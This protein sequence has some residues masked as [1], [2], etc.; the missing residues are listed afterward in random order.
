MIHNIRN[1]VVLYG[2]D[3]FVRQ[4]SFL[5]MNGKDL[6]ICFFGVFWKCSFFGRIVWYSM[7][8]YDI[9]WPYCLLDN[10]IE[11]NQEITWRLLKLSHWRSHYLKNICRFV[12]T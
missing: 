4:T 8:E 11:K 5:S 12:Q 1:D 7:I 2:G 9:V 10:G 6:Y 3:D